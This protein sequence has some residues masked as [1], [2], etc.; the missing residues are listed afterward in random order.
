[1]ANA[2]HD[3]VADEIKTRRGLQASRRSFSC[4]LRKNSVIINILV[5]FVWQTTGVELLMKCVNIPE[6]TDSVVSPAI[7]HLHCFEMFQLYSEICSI[8]EGGWCE[9][10]SV[11]QSPRHDILLVS[12]LYSVSNRAAVLEETLMPLP[13]KKRKFETMKFH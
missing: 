8:T 9:L 12:H 4:A 3:H 10:E 11:T 1:M 5:V 2:F 7:V 13:K 6:T